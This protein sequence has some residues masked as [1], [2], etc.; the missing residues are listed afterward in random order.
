LRPQRLTEAQILEDAALCR[1]LNRRG[2]MRQLREAIMSDPRTFEKCGR[3]RTTVVYFLI[4]ALYVVGVPI[5]WLNMIYRRFHARTR[6]ERR[7]I[8]LTVEN[9]ASH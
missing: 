3:Y 1:R 8:I 5:R 2:G 4:L 7:G 9:E 6:E